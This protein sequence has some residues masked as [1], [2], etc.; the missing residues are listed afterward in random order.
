MQQ[1]DAYLP[2]GY[3]FPAKI[4]ACS[5]SCT[6]WVVKILA[7]AGRVLLNLVI[8]NT[9]FILC[10]PHYVQPCV[11]SIKCV[12]LMERLTLYMGIVHLGGAFEVSTTRIHVHAHTFT[13][14]SI[15]QSCNTRQKSDL[16]TQLSS[17]PDYLTQPLR[18]FLTSTKQ[19]IPTTWNQQLTA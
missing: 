13:S 6:V 2:V 1:I 10:T 11:H 17:F 15:A 3:P 18:S 19:T 5:Q 8:S 14:C 9:H 7:T 12:L 4:F 16:I